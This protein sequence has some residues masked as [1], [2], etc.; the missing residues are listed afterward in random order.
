MAESFRSKF[1]NMVF[2]SST[3]VKTAACAT[4]GSSLYAWLR[5]H[6]T[7]IPSNPDT[8]VQE[9]EPPASAMEQYV[10]HGG[11]V[12][13][14]EMERL[15]EVVVMYLFN[16]L[17]PLHTQASRQYSDADTTSLLHYLAY[18]IPEADK[19]HVVDLDTHS[20]YF[21][22]VE[23]VRA[24]FDADDYKFR[25]VVKKDNTNGWQDISIPLRVRF[26][27]MLKTVVPHGRHNIKDSWVDI[28]TN[29]RTSLVE[30]IHEYTGASAEKVDT[31]VLRPE[32]IQWE[33][34]VY[35]AGDVPIRELLEDGDGIK[36]FLVSYWADNYLEFSGYKLAR[37]FN[38]L[39]GYG[40]FLYDQGNNYSRKATNNFFIP[41]A[42]TPGKKRW[43]WTD[44]PETGGGDVCN[45]KDRS[46]VLE[47]VIQNG[48]LCVT[49]G[50]KRMVAR[51]QRHAVDDALHEALDMVIP[52]IIGKTG[53][54]GDTDSTEKTMIDISKVLI[55][56]IDSMF[57]NLFDMSLAEPQDSVPK[58]DGVLDD[59]ILQRSKESFMN[60]C[61][62]ISA[63]T[64]NSEFTAESVVDG[65][66]KEQ[67]IRMVKIYIHTAREEWL[68]ERH[69]TPMTPEL[70]ERVQKIYTPAFWNTTE[71]DD[72]TWPALK[73]S[74]TRTKLLESLNCIEVQNNS[75]L[76]SLYEDPATTT[77]GVG[78]LHA[79]RKNN[80]ACN[81]LECGLSTNVLQGYYDRKA[82]ADVGE[83]ISSCDVTSVLRSTQT[84]IRGLEKFIECGQHGSKRPHAGGCFW[85]PPALKTTRSPYAAY[86]CYYVLE[87]EHGVYGGVKKH[88][89][90]S[91]AV[92]S[93]DLITFAHT[94]FTI[95]DN[96][97]IWNLLNTGTE[98]GTTYTPQVANIGFV[99]NGTEIK[100]GSVSDRPPSWAGI[101]YM[102]FTKLRVGVMDQPKVANT[103]NRYVNE[104]LNNT[105]R[106]TGH[107]IQH[108]FKSFMFKIYNSEVFTKS[109]YPASK[110]V[111]DAERLE[112]LHQNAVELRAFIVQEATYFVDRLHQCCADS[113]LQ[114]TSPNEHNYAFPALRKHNIQLPTDG[115][116]H[117]TGEEEDTLRHMQLFYIVFGETLCSISNDLANVSVCNF[118]TP[119]ELQVSTNKLLAGRFKSQIPRFLQHMTDMFFG[120]D[121]HHSLVR[122]LKQQSSKKPSSPTLEVI[123]DIPTDAGLSFKPTLEMIPEIQTPITW[124]FK[125]VCANLTGVLIQLRHVPALTAVE[126]PAWQGRSPSSKAA[127]SAIMQLLKPLTEHQT[128]AASDMECDHNQLCASTVECELSEDEGTEHSKLSKEKHR[129]MLTFQLYVQVYEKLFKYYKAGSD[130]PRKQSGAVHIQTPASETSTQQDLFHE[131]RMLAMRICEDQMHIVQRHAVM[132]GEYK[133]SRAWELLFTLFIHQRHLF[134]EMN[135]E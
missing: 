90:G 107:T 76:K 77:H 62:K 18:V 30:M 75:S 37:L 5:D 134:A 1:E 46:N 26:T 55:E 122:Q 58:R 69:T 103:A 110:G 116:V 102:T 71:I 125:L 128:K 53:T 111:S 105:R 39:V 17:K 132:D 40:E 35:A 22:R 118:N 10:H 49:D 29:F 112:C 45:T 52:L 60:E 56:H 81:P 67:V 123:S 101:C 87:G 36:Q 32:D 3:D 70:L 88:H 27:N 7:S 95:V 51:R 131:N 33:T 115:I 100:D 129:A 82:Q 121:L 63:Q 38:G 34:A 114:V 64:Y 6:P 4:T 98:K 24:I 13:K 80:C 99:H 14:F 16:G 68:L 65:R 61:Y 86:G 59:D 130:N 124:T 12:R 31:W 120:G 89:A 96:P 19:L 104:I 57:K 8:V 11:F 106:I 2:N 42:T 66:V 20:G 109:F 72:T 119:Q 54:A 44:L 94:L 9:A 84:L 25:V 21:D 47:A 85:T 41:D 91:R 83:F 135:S 117:K 79:A 97:G 113:N 127:E 93:D 92:H 78:Y 74:I 133:N 28:T 108:A 15:F 23:S 48:E 126:T 43:L 50:F 73:P